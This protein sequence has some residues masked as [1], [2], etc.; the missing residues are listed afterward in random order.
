MFG[1]LYHY[2]FSKVP[3]TRFGHVE[4]FRLNF[5]SSSFTIHIILLHPFVM[6]YGYIIISLPFFLLNKV[7]FLG[8]PQFKGNLYVAT[9]T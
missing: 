4:K 8:L 5:S 3:T 7:L 9:K 6:V 1:Q 2:F